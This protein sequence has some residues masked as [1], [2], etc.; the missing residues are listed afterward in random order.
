MDIRTIGF[1]YGAND[2]LTPLYVGTRTAL[3]SMTVLSTPVTIYTGAPGWVMTGI[4]MWLSG[5]ATLAVAQNVTV[6][7]KSGA[8]N[9]LFGFVTCGTTPNINGIQFYNAYAL[10]LYCR[11]ANDALTVQINRTLTTGSIL[12]NVIYAPAGAQ[13]IGL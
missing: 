1:P 4:D 10:N 6:T 3:A 11:T 7:V 5:D 9:I 8:T 12:A 2:V 13:S